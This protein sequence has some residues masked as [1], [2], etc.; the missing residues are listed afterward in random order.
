MAYKVTTK[1]KARIALVFRTKQ[2]AQTYCSQAAVQKCE[3]KQTS[4][5]PTV[6]FGDHRVKLRGA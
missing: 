4:A 3:I 2:E 5:K 6:T 1:P